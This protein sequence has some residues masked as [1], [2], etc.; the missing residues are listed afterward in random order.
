MTEKSFAKDQGVISNKGK[1]VLIFCPAW[2]TEIPPVGIS[3]ISAYLKKNGYDVK[4]FDFNIE[5]FYDQN[6]ED[7]KL[8]DIN[9]Q[10]KKMWE[11]ID[12]FPKVLKDYFSEKLDI[13]AEKIVEEKPDIVGL[14]V[15]PNNKLISM[16]LAE[17]IK[18]KSKNVKIVLG[19]PFF[20]SEIPEKGRIGS[21]RLL[22]MCIPYTFDSSNLDYSLIHRNEEKR[23]SFQVDFFKKRSNLLF[24]FI[25]IVNDW[26]IGEEMVIVLSAEKL[27]S[28]MM[29]IHVLDDF[30]SS[31]MC[32]ISMEDL[33]KNNL[34]MIGKDLFIKVPYSD[35]IRTDNS[36]YDFDWSKIRELHLI[37]KPKKYREIIRDYTISGLYIRKTEVSFNENLINEPR[38]MRIFPKNTR[39]ALVNRGEDR[40]IEFFPEDSLEYFELKIEYDL[41][42]L[43][44]MEKISLRLNI[45]EY[46]G[47]HISV[48]IEVI[49]EKGVKSYFKSRNMALEK[50]FFKRRLSDIEFFADDFN[51]PE[52]SDKKRICSM[53]F[54][55][56]FE[57]EKIS[58]R[59]YSLFNIIL[60]SN[61]E[62][63]NIMKEDLTNEGIEKGLQSII[64]D[65]NDYYSDFFTEIIINILKTY[66]ID[67]IILGEGEKAMLDLCDK[68]C[69]GQDI[70]L[71]NTVY[72]KEEGLFYYK[73]PDRLLEMESLP[74]PDF[75]DFNFDL[76]RK[77]P[78]T[79]SR[80][81]RN[82]CKFCRETAFWKYFRCRSA[83]NVFQEIILRIKEHFGNKNFEEK[84]VFFCSESSI[85]TDYEMLK[86]LSSLII[87]SKIKI[88]DKWINIRDIV[89]IEG[90]ARV[91]PKISL[92]DYMLFKKAGLNIISFGIESGSDKVLKAM[93]K[94]VS[95]FL[96]MKAIK[97]AHK[98]RIFVMI[99]LMVGYPDE[100]FMDFLKTIWFVIKVRKYVSMIGTGFPC[101]IADQ[102]DLY[103]RPLEHKIIFK[104]GY[105]LNWKKIGGFNNLKIRMFRLYILKFV[106]KM[107]NIR[108]FDILSNVENHEDDKN[109]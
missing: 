90:M 24:K 44:K 52:D 83:A 94:G 46:Y 68:T 82:H 105:L 19:G 32:S 109:K 104:K 72:K 62:K 98:A 9:Y 93:G 37:F 73:G 20:A 85:N 65:F 3:Y 66:P 57:S 63:I 18:G 56:E 14:S 23:L 36:F 10:A 101:I 49:D 79:F 13:W 80:G 74:Y 27:T 28:D 4:C 71:L 6:I 31:V 33:F 43:E 8:W 64:P 5:A 39:T 1:I 91:I 76:Y 38:M 102:S 35:F 12:L 51:I 78:I 16:L 67:Y 58:N 40:W 69:M 17:K 86:E 84:I 107:L 45:A 34:F 22:D 89:L 11:D 21:K 48:S 97:N 96:A 30:K 41:G 108:V 70:N 2:T 106:V 50:F 77:I 87:V 61:G 53:S 59:K 25:P 47:D 100:N 15:F 81:C 42:F 26:T 7:R 88:Y 29:E 92:E 75:S 55:I 60:K 54:R 99:N 95:S 103:K